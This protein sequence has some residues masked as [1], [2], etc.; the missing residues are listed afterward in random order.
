LRSPLWVK[1]I[2][3]APG[4]WTTPDFAMAGTPGVG[5]TFAGARKMRQSAAKIQA[6]DSP[7]P[8]PIRD[9]NCDGAVRGFD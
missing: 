2:V 4:V 3:L 5:A 8:I 7:E 6:T 1:G 9:G